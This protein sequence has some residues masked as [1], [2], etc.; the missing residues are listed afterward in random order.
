MRSRYSAYCHNEAQY[1][2]STHQ[3]ENLKLADIQ[4][5]IDQTQWLGLTIVHSKQGTKYDAVGW[6]EFIAFYQDDGIKQLHENSYFTKSGEQWLY[7]SGDQLPPVKL[8]R[9]DPCF[10]ASGKKYKKCHGI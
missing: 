5:T 8:K 4:Q 1:L 6:V 10:C 7:I 9:N 2:F 3:S